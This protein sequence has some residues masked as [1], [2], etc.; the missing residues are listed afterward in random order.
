MA[1][2]NPGAKA[3]QPTVSAS[4][5]LR[6]RLP[7]RGDPHHA[8]PRS[9]CA[10]GVE[11]QIAKWQKPRN[12]SRKPQLTDRSTNPP[13]RSVPL[14]LGSWLRARWTAP[15]PQGTHAPRSR[16]P[17]TSILNFFP[18]PFR[19]SYQLLRPPPPLPQT[20]REQQRI[21]WEIRAEFRCGTGNPSSFLPREATRGRAPR[22]GHKSETFLKR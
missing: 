8:W 13:W 11:V 18:L 16:G 7:N 14:A 17:T 6:D 21:R 5:R 2:A 15:K 19:V 9:E 12:L 10:S 3:T 20:R 4:R 1:W 22:S